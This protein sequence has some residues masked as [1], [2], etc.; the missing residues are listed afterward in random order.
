MATVQNG[1]MD[2]VEAGKEAAVKTHTRPVRPTKRLLSEDGNSCYNILTDHDI[3]S[4]AET[5]P[6]EQPEGVHPMI[7]GMLK[8]IRKDV[9]KL[10][11]V[12]KRMAVVEDQLDYDGAEIANLQH[13]VQKLVESNKTLAGRVML[14][15]AT[16][17]R[18]KTTIT[19]LKMGSMRDN[20]IIKTSGPTYKETREEQTES[21][22]RKFL[23]DEMRIPNVENMYIN[24]S[25][26]MGQANGNFNRMLIDRLQ[27]RRDQTA[28]I[29][30]ASNLQGTNHS[31]TKQ[32]P[33][34]VEE[35]RQ[36]A[37]A[38]YKKARANRQAARFDGGTL[39]IGGN[40]VPKYDPIHHPATSDTL[41]GAAGP[42]KPRGVS[43]VMTEQGHTFQAWAIP[44]DVREGM[45]QLLQLDEL[46]GALACMKTS[47]LMEICTQDCLL[48]V[49][50]A[51]CPQITW[52]S[53]SRIIRICIS[54]EP[55]AKVNW[56]WGQV[57]WMLAD[58][59]DGLWSSSF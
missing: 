41:L 46:A 59:R 43:D 24:S 54:P 9:A 11:D 42:A 17:D 10:N 2:Y 4:Q 32:Y 36:F 27:R 8:L 47:I 26:R 12:E 15:E 23:T 19:D 25:H 40:P 50:S 35:R 21:T 20:I 13:K 1:S 29:D 57:G 45:D 58:H 18:Q 51:I 48:S 44:A 7:W 39:V 52:P 3:D 16:I 5:F 37:W 14:A 22:V 31:I 38:D 53:S 30:N 6:D 34:E 55:G 56:H 49:Y 28:I 33:P